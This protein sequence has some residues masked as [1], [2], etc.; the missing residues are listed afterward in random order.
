MNITLMF[1]VIPVMKRYFAD[2]NV[3]LTLSHA[4]FIEKFHLKYLRKLFEALGDIIKA[5]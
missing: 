4:K 2:E 1:T 3:L 5:I